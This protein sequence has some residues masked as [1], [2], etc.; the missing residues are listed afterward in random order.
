M[1]CP[2]TQDFNDQDAIDTESDSFDQGAIQYG[3]EHAGDL[4]KQYLKVTDNF[5]EMAKADDLIAEAIE[6]IGDRRLRGG[7][8]LMGSCALQLMQLFQKAWKSHAESDQYSDYVRQA[9]HEQC[10]ADA[11]EFHNTPG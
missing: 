5:Q 1:T 8:D 6:I 3:E 10:L 2:V 4:C 7:S 9:Y 11:E